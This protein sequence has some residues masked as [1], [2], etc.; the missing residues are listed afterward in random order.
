MNTEFVAMTPPD[1]SVCEIIDSVND[2]HLLD[3]SGYWDTKNQF[4]FADSM[5]KGTFHNYVGTDSEWRDT[6]SKKF[7]N[8]LKGWNSK[9]VNRG[10][11]FTLVSM[12]TSSE[13]I[14]SDQIEVQVNADPAA[15]MSTEKVSVKMAGVQYSSQPR[16]ILY[17]SNAWW[18]YYDMGNWFKIEV[19]SY[20]FDNGG[21]NNWDDD[22]GHSGDDDA[23][24]RGA[25]S[26]S[27]T[28]FGKTFPINVD[29]T[30]SANPGWGYPTPLPTSNPDPTW[31]PTLKPTQYPTVRKPTQRPTASTPKPTPRPTVA[32]AH[33]SVPSTFRTVPANTDHD[34][35]NKKAIPINKYSLWVAAGVNMGA[36][37]VEDLIDFD[38]DSQYSDDDPVVDTRSRRKLQSQRQDAQGASERRTNSMIKKGPENTFE[39]QEEEEHRRLNFRTGS[40]QD[41]GETFPYNHNLYPMVFRKFKDQMAMAPVWCT[42][43]NETKGSFCWINQ[44]QYDDKGAFLFPLIQHY[45][46]DCDECQSWDTSTTA[47]AASQKAYDDKCNKIDTEYVLGFN[48]GAPDKPYYAQFNYTNNV[49]YNM[50]T[51]T[52]KDMMKSGFSG[53]ININLWNQGDGK[54][55]SGYKGG[56]YGNTFLNGNFYPV[57]NTHC[58]TPLSMAIST[59]NN[60]QACGTSAAKAKYCNAPPR[61]PTWKC[62]YGGWECYLGSMAKAFAFVAFLYTV[63]LMIL[64]IA[65]LGSGQNKSTPAIE[66]SAGAEMAPVMPKEGAPEGP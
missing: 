61:S 6:Y 41:I 32:A 26:S 52:K 35:V 1:S 18:K 60:Q 51:V 9:F 46:R 45:D 59:S 17:A 39:R 19:P 40:K 44:G 14:A 58:T 11:V 47:G 63:T 5:V 25:V 56:N 55:P 65:G 3:N 28:Y 8:V 57:P 22:D 42:P 2:E 48:Y 66:S 49:G 34:Y 54:T 15:I 7:F 10:S 50:A 36:I 62:T 27:N 13:R 37:S 38:G 20:I 21:G 16:D 33:N 23:G 29:D 31:K 12:V 30:A 64:D 24:P 43:K 53:Y 4:A